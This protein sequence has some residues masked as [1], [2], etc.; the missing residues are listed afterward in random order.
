MIATAFEALF[1]VGIAVFLL[2]FYL[3]CWSEKKGYLKLHK[4]KL[5]HD[6][7]LE[8]MKRRIKR[9][10][11][12]QSGFIGRWMTFGGGFYGAAAVYTYTIVEIAEIARFVFKMLNPA[13]WSFDIGIDLLVRFIINSVENFVDAIVWFGYWGDG[14]Y[15]AETA[16]WI[17]VAYGT[18]WAGSWLG[19]DFCRHENNME[20]QLQ[21]PE[22]LVEF[23]RT[24]KWSRVPPK[25]E[26]TAE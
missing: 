26:G 19:K 7:H 14:Q 5:S 18:Y 1:Q 15:G 3:V 9:D 22:E 4:S 23:I 10:K 13:N 2:G 24:I 6:K 25:S 16:V 11:E 12:E 21:W 17:G 20:T 8:V